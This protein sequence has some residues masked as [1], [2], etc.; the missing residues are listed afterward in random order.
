MTTRTAP[1]EKDAKPAAPKHVHRDD[2]THLKSIDQLGLLRDGS[3]EKGPV[4]ALFTHDN[5]SIHH[6]GNHI[7]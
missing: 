4:D 5:D 3:D 1:V 2:Y 6:K 7:I